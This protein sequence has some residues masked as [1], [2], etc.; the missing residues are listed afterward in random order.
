MEKK[1]TEKYVSPRAELLGVSSE[2]ILVLSEGD[3]NQ[4]AWDPQSNGAVE[5]EE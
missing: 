4:G 3:K 1:I 5:E 2:D